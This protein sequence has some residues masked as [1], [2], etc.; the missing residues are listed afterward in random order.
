[1]THLFRWFAV[2]AGTGLLACGHS[3]PF[4]SPT[5]GSNQPFDPSPPVRLTLNRGPDRRAAWLPDGS[6]ILYSTQAEDGQDHDVCLAEMPATGGTQRS[7]QCNLSPLGAQLT[8]AL[9]SA[10]P[11]DD[12]RLAFVAASSPIGA[13][14]PTDQALAIGPRQNPADRTSLL[15][16]PYTIPGH[17][18]HGGISQLRWLGPSRLLFLGEAVN[19]ITPCLG[20]QK[21]TVRSGL[22]A[23]LL[24][25]GAGAG[26]PQAIPGSQY[27]SG[28]SP[29]GSPDE[30]YY[31]LAGDSRVYR[32]ELSSGAV[33]QVYDFGA[34][35]IV[36]D[37]HVVGSQMAATVGGK[38]S[39]VNDPS[40]GP[41]QWDS[42]GLVHVVDLTSGADVILQAQR[43]FFRRPQLS[44][45][46]AAVV[47]EGYP[48]TIIPG[49]V[50]GQFD[51]VVARVGDLIRFGSP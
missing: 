29:G 14:T 18:T 35:G 51:T 48:L 50:E 34:A 49:A 43:M 27:A 25:L 6:G 17:P 11:T 7:L 20:C 31:T 32:Q 46:G 39:F 12:G 42:G 22:D 37:V 1:M 36:R 33:S 23:V 9:E 44:S 47:A 45:S 24:D 13:L 28:V 21:D 5:F 16:I 4:E 40:L 15:D 8:E 19:I 30:I 10:A 26:V 41:T 3:E 2:L 38:V